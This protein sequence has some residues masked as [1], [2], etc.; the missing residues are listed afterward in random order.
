MFSLRPAR[1][2]EEGLSTA[3]RTITAGSVQCFLANWDVSHSAAT[4]IGIE[5]TYTASH[6]D[7]SSIN[8]S[9]RVFCT[10]R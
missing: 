7:Y 1:A 6:T 4:T 10:E 5:I 8:L 3:S 9:G 2:Y